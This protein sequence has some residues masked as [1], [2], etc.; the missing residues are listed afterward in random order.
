MRKSRVTRPRGVEGTR[1]NRDGTHYKLI[2]V[3]NI[4]DGV[5][6]N[7]TAILYVRLSF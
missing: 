6:N 1:L 4:C 3:K 2:G 5:L 7:D